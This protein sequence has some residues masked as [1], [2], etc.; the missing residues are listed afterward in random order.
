MRLVGELVI[1][2][3]RLE[4]G[5]GRMET[6]AAPARL[7]PLQEANLAMERQLRDLREAVMCIRMVPVGSDIAHWR[8]PAPT[9]RLAA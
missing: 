5:L 8:W 3:A 2:R 9:E 6:E 4:D 7:R 1:S